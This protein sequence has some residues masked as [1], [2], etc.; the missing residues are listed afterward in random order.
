MSTTTAPTCTPIFGVLTRAG[1]LIVNEHADCGLVVSIPRDELAAVKHLP[2]YQRVAVVEADK[3][4]ALI[5][6][7]NAYRTGG[8]TE[9]IL[10][11]GDGYIKVGHDCA[12]I[13]AADLPKGATET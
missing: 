3:I 12:I 2:M 11:R 5:E 7:V 4:A 1:S 8:V 9:E 10:R 6:E 13:S